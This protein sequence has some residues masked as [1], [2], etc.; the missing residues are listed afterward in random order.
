M[1]WTELTHKITNAARAAFLAMQSEAKGEK[2]YVFALYTDADC[3]TVGVTANSI[4]KHEE[5]MAEEGISDTQEALGYKWYTG[6]WF[7][8]AWG[9]DG[10]QSIC[11]ELSEA[12]NAASNEG[13]FLEFKQNVHSCMIK[14]LADLDR[15]RIFQ[16]REDAV[17][18]ISSTD[19]DE[20][21]ILENESAK[22]LND[23]RLAEL[24]LGRYNSA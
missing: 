9:D 17:L 23:R 7:Y 22:Q 1:N 2:F 10:F 3:Y 12:S 4:Q 15:D 11:E 5:K 14:C 24:F 20:S 8:E 13:R 18:L 19:N 21:E 6:E 16:E